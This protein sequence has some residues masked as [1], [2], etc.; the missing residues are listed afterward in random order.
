MTIRAIAAK[1]MYRNMAPSLR[2]PRAT[3]G[4]QGMSPVATFSSVDGR[5][6]RMLNGDQRRR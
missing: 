5:V 4:E 3:I 6:V 2:V 1:R